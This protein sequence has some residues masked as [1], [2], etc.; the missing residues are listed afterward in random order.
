VF[1]IREP[2]RFPITSNRWLLALAVGCLVY[3]VLSGWLGGSGFTLA[4]GVTG[5]FV[6]L[7]TVP[8]AGIWRRSLPTV[9]AGIEA[10]LT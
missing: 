2:L 9:G 8:V 7:R 4:V 1:F 6:F 5:G 10:D 3:S